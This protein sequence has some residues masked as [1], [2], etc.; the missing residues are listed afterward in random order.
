MSQNRVLKEHNKTLLNWFKEIVFADDNASE[1]L[2]K[3]ANGP[4]RNVITWQGYGVN[5]YSFYTKS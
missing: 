4:K 2:I 3:L 1:M 5:K